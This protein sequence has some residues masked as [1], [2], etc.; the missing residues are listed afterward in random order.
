MGNYYTPFSLRVSEDVIAKMKWI[1]K[2]HHRSATKEMEVA[3]E[4]YIAA[5]EKEH[6]T[7]KIEE[8]P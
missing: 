6:G 5:Y 8:E 4:Q 2:I 7:I 3:L 1:G